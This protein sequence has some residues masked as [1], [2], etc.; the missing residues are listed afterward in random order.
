MKLHFKPA[1]F[2]FVYEDGQTY[3]FN[4]SPAYCMDKLRTSKR[5]VATVYQKTGE[6][7]VKISD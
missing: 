3:E 1:S 5:K 4:G 2:R 6:H 7:F